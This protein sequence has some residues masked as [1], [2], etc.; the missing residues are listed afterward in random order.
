MGNGVST[1][2]GN[3][4]SYGIGDVS[5]AA[6]RKQHDWSQ[7]ARTPIIEQPSS[8]LWSPRDPYSVGQCGA[9]ESSNSTE[10]NAQL[11]AYVDDYRITRLS[12]WESAKSAGNSQLRQ[13][14]RQLELSSAEDGEVRA[15]VNG[16]RERRKK[17]GSDMQVEPNTDQTAYTSGRKKSTTSTETALPKSTYTH[18]DASAC[19]AAQY[20]EEKKSTYTCDDASA[21]PISGRAATRHTEEGT[22]MKGLAPLQLVPTRDTPFLTNMTLPDGTSAEEQ[23]SLESSVKKEQPRR[24]SAKEIGQELAEIRRLG[25]LA[26]EL[27]RQGDQP[28][29]AAVRVSNLESGFYLDRHVGVVEPLTGATFEQ[30]DQPEVRFDNQP[31]N[32]HGA[33]PD[34]AGIYGLLGNAGSADPN[35][36]F[37]MP[38]Q[39]AN[40]YDRTE[41]AYNAYPINRQSSLSDAQ[42]LE[43]NKVLQEQVPQSAEI[44]YPMAQMK[45][46]DSSCRGE[47]AIE[48]ELRAILQDTSTVQRGVLPYNEQDPHE[49]DELDMQHWRAKTDTD[50]KAGA[51]RHSSRQLHSTAKRT[52]NPADAKVG[53]TQHPS[54]KSSISYRSNLNELPSCRRISCLSNDPSPEKSRSTKRKQQKRRQDRAECRRRKRQNRRLDEQPNTKVFSD[55]TAVKVNQNFD[56]T[57]EEQPRVMNWETLD[58]ING[59][60]ADFAKLK[61]QGG[62]SDPAMKKLSEDFDE[63]N[64]SFI[65]WENRFVHRISAS[66][67]K[68]AEASY[69]GRETARRCNW[70]VSRTQG[71]V[72]L[73]GTDGAVA[74]GMATVSVRIGDQT[75]EQLQLFVSPHVDDSLT[76][77]RDVVSRISVR[78]GRLLL[79]LYRGE[80]ID[81]LA[82]EPFRLLFDATYIEEE[83]AEQ[84]NEVHGQ[85]NAIT[86]EQSHKTPEKRAAPSISEDYL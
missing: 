81:T 43:V 71:K 80:V 49:N 15:E 32:A 61:Q 10:D 29:G 24:V 5:D 8:A 72:V 41:S 51:T 44:A 64:K 70:P 67:C 21:R 52:G 13:R 27:D 45:R 63:I 65:E 66:V 28:D 68:S 69:V 23:Q 19:A 2:Q 40:L 9:R 86:I 3:L 53:S 37:Y 74:T 79:T 35:G 22:A 1:D 42:M 60:R 73:T 14:R 36:M 39:E 17:T 7:L 50:A 55:Y 18:A 47:L 6:D 56:A 34:K 84:L 76:L 59:I 85:R 26:R 83:E 4:P 58:R 33:C 12:A 16:R 38:R 25:R 48:S 54:L 82:E 77:G 20:A 46:D 78:D 31:G 11:D 57:K 75:I 62:T 30:A